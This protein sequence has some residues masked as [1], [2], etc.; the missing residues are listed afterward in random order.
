MPPI[1]SSSSQELAN[2]EGRILLAL[3]DIKNGRIQ[4]LRVAAKLYNISHSTLYNRATG[5]SLRVETSRHRRKVT[6]LEEDSL[7]K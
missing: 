4:S 5:V 2:K 1:R 6:E 7:V 3:N